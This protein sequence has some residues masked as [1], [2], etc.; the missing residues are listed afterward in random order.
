MSPWV[1]ADC[2]HCW[3]SWHHCLQDGDKYILIDVPDENFT[4]AYSMIL[5]SQGSPVFSSLQDP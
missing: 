4:E 3:G 2:G 5:T 1:S